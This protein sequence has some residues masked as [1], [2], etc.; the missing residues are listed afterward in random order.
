MIL[1]PCSSNGIERHTKKAARGRATQTE[2]S[3]AKTE[4]GCKLAPRFARVAKWQT[5]QT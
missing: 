3:V 1:L 2:I 5:R 4:L